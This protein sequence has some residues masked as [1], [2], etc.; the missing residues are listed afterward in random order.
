MTA[1]GVSKGKIVI[2]G[3]GSSLLGNGLGGI[4]DSH[5]I[6]VRFNRFETKGFVPDVGRKTSIWFCNRNVNHSSLFRVLR[7]ESYTEIY[8]HT[9]GDRHEAALTFQRA[10]EEIDRSARIVEVPASTYEE[11]RKFIGTDYRFFSTGAIAVWLMIERFGKVDLVGFDW[12]RNP[13]R[14]HYFNDGQLPP[15]PLNGHRPVEEKK[16][17]E[18]LASEGKLGFL[19]KGDQA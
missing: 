6:V 1:T 17:F 2:V 7:H 10:L 12:W 3:N 5:E 18:R 16:F 13:A 19:G 9:W 4:I 11:M 15:D 8:V 14:I